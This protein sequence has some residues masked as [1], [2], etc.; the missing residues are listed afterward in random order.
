MK[1]KKSDFLKYWRPIRQYMK[2][3]YGVCQADLDM[4][5]FL[6]TEPYFTRDKFDE[7]NALLP[8]DKQR[9]E[10]LR[11]NG[12]IESYK[13]VMIGRRKKY[14]LSMKSMRMIES[15]YSYLNG[16]E[17]PIKSEVNPM[18]KRNVSYTDKVY[19]YFIME[20]RKAT[21]KQPPRPEA[22]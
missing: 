16:E 14:G 21:T 8:W 3:K 15:I 17:I 18:F 9:F 20:L 11:E 13:N 1:S 5:L 2:V 22:E 4:L 12:W 7:F 19:R 6:Y 10:K